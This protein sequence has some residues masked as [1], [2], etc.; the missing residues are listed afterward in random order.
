MGQVI[1]EYNLQEIDTFTSG[2]S[3]IA[4]FPYITDLLLYIKTVV[5]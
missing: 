5:F 4:S 2:Q 1:D 3:Q